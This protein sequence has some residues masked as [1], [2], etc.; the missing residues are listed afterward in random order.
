[1]TDDRGDVSVPGFSDAI[2][3]HAASRRP[4]AASR[5][6]LA[7]RWRKYDP[8]IGTGLKSALRDVPW[9]NL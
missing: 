1:M 6:M 3:V 2:C 8:G 5:H 4:P 9:D 7:K